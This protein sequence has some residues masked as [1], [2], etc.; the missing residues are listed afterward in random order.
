VDAA[1]GLIKAR[2]DE[3][4]KVK[5]TILTM[6]SPA[7]AAEVEAIKAAEANV[8]GAHKTAS[9]AKAA[10]DKALKTQQTAAELAESIKAKLAAA[11]APKKGAKGS[12]K[13]GK[14]DIVEASATVEGAKA[15]SVPL[16][17]AEI[18]Q[19]MKDLASGKEGADDRT[20]LIAKLF[21]EL[22]D[23]GRLTPKLLAEEMNALLDKM[24]AVLPKKEA[25]VVK[26]S[27]E[28]VKK[29]K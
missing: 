6:D 8:K 19:S 4:K 3:L 28:K 26:E 16:G 25:A 17:L 9:A 12:K 21:K 15:G 1:E 11:R 2:V 27:S 10:L 18:R 13:I 22:F 24:G 23:G 14:K 20:V 7:G 5:N 29:V